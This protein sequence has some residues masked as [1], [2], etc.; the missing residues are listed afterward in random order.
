VPAALAK[1][2]GPRD[3]ISKAWQLDRLRREIGMVS[4]KKAPQHLHQSLPVV[5]GVGY[6]CPTL[7][8]SLGV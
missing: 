7:S 5:F 1:D 6:L 8:L 3:K 2:F 4:A